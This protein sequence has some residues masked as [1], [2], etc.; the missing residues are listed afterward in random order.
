MT[1]HRCTRCGARYF[2]T[3]PYA[4][5]NKQIRDFCPECIEKFQ[6]EHEGAGA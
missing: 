4:K 3:I 6:R 5:A 1:E 2:L